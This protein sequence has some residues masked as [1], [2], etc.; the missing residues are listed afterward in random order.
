MMQNNLKQ[1][2]R[3][4]E[5]VIY[6]IGNHSSPIMTVK[7]GYFMSLNDNIGNLVPVVVPIQQKN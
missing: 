2:V 4:F 7:Y 3:D 1:I 5:T 6:G